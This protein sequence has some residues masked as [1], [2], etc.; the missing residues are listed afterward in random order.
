MIAGELVHEDNRDAR[1]AVLVIEL[2][3]VVG[4]QVRHGDGPPARAAILEHVTR[5][6]EP[7]LR[8]RTCSDKEAER[9]DEFIPLCPILADGRNAYSAACATPRR[10]SSCDSF[11]RA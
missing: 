10:T 4:G 11:R 5:K 8:K 3:A 6:W 1:S 7:V 9:D 2:D